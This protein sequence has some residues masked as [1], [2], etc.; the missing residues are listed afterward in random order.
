[1]NYYTIEIDERVWNYLKSKAIPFEDTP[2]SV[3]NRIFFSEGNFAT[4]SVSDVS[5]KRL[6]PR[7][8]DGTPKALAQILEVLYEIKKLGLTR[9]QATS[10]VAQRRRTAPQT[11]I[12]KY[13]RQ[14]NKRA[15]EI[16]RLLQ[17]K[18]LREF[19]LLLENKF[20]N[21]KDVINSFFKT[22]QFE[23][24][25]DFHALNY[26]DST[27]QSESEYNHRHKNMINI[28]KNRA[29]GKS[30]IYIE[31]IDTDHALLVTSSGKIKSLEYNLF[32]EPKEK[33]KDYCLSQKLITKQQLK[34]YYEFIDN[35]SFDR[36]STR[37]PK[38]PFVSQKTFSSTIP[39]KKITQD[40]LIP[41]IIKILHK[42]GG[43]ASKK[44]VDE[45]I[46]QIFQDEFRDEWYQGVVSYG[47]PRW[48]HNIAFAKERA[49]LLH[50]YIKSAE[51]SGRGIWELT[52]EGEKYYQ[53]VGELFKKVPAV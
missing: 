14:L 18:D 5:K 6:T 19:K 10:I 36:T 41:Y 13:C 44:Q 46:Y 23:A 51:E 37:F 50:G 48:K 4:L 52:Q 22:L 28:C 1:M 53:T 35:V 30:F 47:I 42:H 26:G 16:D 27:V 9:T 34:Q 38:E 24:K 3:L 21:H 2:N 15:Y 12:D 39:D 20:T 29:S 25:K 31:D 11:I 8:P 32:D 33:N 43:R 7:L 49:K 40:D 45:E 17:E